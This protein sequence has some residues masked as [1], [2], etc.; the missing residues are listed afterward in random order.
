MAP[1]GHASIQGSTDIPTLF[2][3]LPGYLAMPKFG[4]DSSTWQ[5]M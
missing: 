3:I 2:D 4:P 5:R 1:R